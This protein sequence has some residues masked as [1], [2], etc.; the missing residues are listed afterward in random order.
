MQQIVIE[1][2]D[3]IKTAFMMAD[4]QKKKEISDLVSLFLDS[5]WNE[6]NLVEVMETISE[7][8]EKRGLTPEI[9]DD[10]LVDKSIRLTRSR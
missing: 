7:N 1:V 9:L 5:S 2:N 8:A 10:L 6:K 3:N 4:E